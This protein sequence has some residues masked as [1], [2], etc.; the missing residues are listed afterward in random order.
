MDIGELM[1]DGWMETGENGLLSH[2]EIN[3]LQIK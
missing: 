2:D 1:D 3:K